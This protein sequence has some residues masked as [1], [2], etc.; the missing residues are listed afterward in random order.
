[1]LLLLVKIMA[2]ERQTNIVITDKLYLESM[3]EKD[4]FKDEQ[5]LIFVEGHISMKSRINY[6]TGR[7]EFLEEQIEKKKNIVKHIGN[8]FN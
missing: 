8:N 6:M 3:I 7:K 2:I 1:M 5:E 4:I